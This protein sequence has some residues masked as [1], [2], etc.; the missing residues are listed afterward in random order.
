MEV[1]A[2]AKINLGLQIL[3]RRA[4]GYR[5]LVT[6]FH[7]IDLY[8]VLTFHHANSGAAMECNHPDVPCDESNLCIRAAN[9]VLRHAR[10]GGVYMTLEKN[11]P[12][13][14]GLGGGS[15]NAGAVLR[16]LPALLGVHIPEEELRHMALELGSDVPFFLMDGCAEGR[17]RGEVLTPLPFRNPWW[18]LTATPDVHVSTSWAYASLGV[19]HRHSAV[20]A[21]DALLRA[22]SDQAL[23]RDVL[24][25][26]FQHI[27]TTA[28][29]A[30]HELLYSM[31]TTGALAA[32]MSGSGSSVFGLYARQDE[33]IAAREA[34]PGQTVCSL[35]AP[36]FSPVPIPASL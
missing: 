5:N 4:D 13:G 2:Y 17:G 29:P 10:S 26:D 21:A 9:A 8:D 35:T 14:A 31:E 32:A 15:S 36:N 34:L 7:H 25:N 3:D 6:V 28:Y 30:I 1:R 12:M 27:V 11:I 16:F 18:I 19:Q 33:A 20:H 22:G 24:H 23:L